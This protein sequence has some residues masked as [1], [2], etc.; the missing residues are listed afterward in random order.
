MKRVSHLFSGATVLVAALFLYSFINSVSTANNK[1]IFDGSEEIESS[2]HYKFDVINALG[3]ENLVDIMVCGSGPAGLSA[4][5]YAARARRRVLV[6][7]GDIPGGQ[8]TKTTEVDNYPGVPYI[9]GDGLVDTM[10]KQAEGFGAEFL[11]DSVTKI[12]VSSWPY[13]VFTEGGETFN[14]MSIIITTGVSPRSLG[15]P[16]EEKFFGRGVSHCATCDGPFYKG[17]NVIVVGGGDSAIEEAMHLSLYASVVTVLV[18]SN[19]MKAAK[20]MQE[21]IEGYPNIKIKYNTV[22]KEILGDN[23]GVSGVKLSNN[24]DKAYILPVS[25]VFIA[26]G[27]IPTTGF[28][29]D[30]IDLDDGNFIK[31]KD[32]TFETSVKGIYAAGDIV[33]GIKRQI[34]TA[35]GT[36]AQACDVC[37]KFL[38]EEVG[39]SA[40]YV[41]KLS[42]S[43]Y[44]NFKN[45][46]SDPF[47]VK[48]ITT[49]SDF[50]KEVSKDDLLVVMDFYTEE[51]ELPGASSTIAKNYAKKAKFF[52]VD[53]K[54][55]SDISSKFKVSQTP[56]RL[57]F[58]DGSIVARQNDFKDEKGFC[59]IVDKILED[60]STMIMS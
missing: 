24:T 45:F 35:V 41:D 16:G 28:V 26:I 51:Q 17:R 23:D 15:I 30:I 38:T 50:D 5:I 52:K 12:D 57:V 33:G 32:L 25:G 59:Q 1:H 34:T 7:E 21:R 31:V 8:P 14:A 13:K 11:G 20:I 37:D 56:C 58:K 36:A 55:V 18:R 43:Y 39:L 3:K 10:R 44:K 19:K 46:G 53:A 60:S 49:A 54:K 42:D 6:L 48:N 40:K 2:S 9:D 29:K 47:E 27:N 22:V 4:A